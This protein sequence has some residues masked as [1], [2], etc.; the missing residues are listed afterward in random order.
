MAKTQP[1]IVT[2]ITDAL[3]PLFGRTVR[4][5][6]G[7][8]SFLHELE[9]VRMMTLAQVVNKPEPVRLESGRNSTPQCFGIFFK[10]QDVLVFV[11]DHVKGTGVNLSGYFI[12]IGDVRLSIGAA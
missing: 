3:R 5:Q 8:H 7:D 2:K 11:V 6:F 12:L 1:E 9:G 10:G 4:V